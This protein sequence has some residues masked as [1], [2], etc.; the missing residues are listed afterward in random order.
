M[1]LRSQTSEDEHLALRFM[2]IL[3]EPDV[4]SHLK[5]ALYPQQLSDKLDQLQTTITRLTDQLR[6]KDETIAKL[7]SR[8][9]DLELQVDSS[10]QYTRRANLRIQGIPEVTGWEDTTQKAL[11]IFNGKMKLE[12][13]LE[14]TAIERSHRIGPKQDDDGNPLTRNII[15]R[16]ASERV[17]D[18]VFRAK[19]ALKAF[20]DEQDNSKRIFIN[21]DLTKYRGLLAF[22]C[23]KLKKDDLISD[24]WTYGGNVMVKQNDNK[25]KLIRDMSDLEDY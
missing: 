11:D 18:I 1:P 21:E 23:R 17:R 20:N 19:G 9:N 8:V 22:K 14:T 6:L 12:P 13:P 2:A 15:V 24:T 16:F 10:E 5:Q 3:K 4:L 25:I 7:E